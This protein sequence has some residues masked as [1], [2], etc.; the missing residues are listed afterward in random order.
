MFLVAE[1]ELSVARSCVAVGMSRSTYYSDP[2]DQMAADCDVISV[3]Q[4]IIDKH[5]GWGFWKCFVWMRQHG[6]GWNHKRIYRVYCNM[7]LNQV[8][9]T[10]KRIPTRERQSIEVVPL[11]NDTWALDFMSDALYNGRRFRTLN[12]LDEGVREAVHIEVDTSLPCSRVIRVL[13]QLK[14]TRGLPRVIRC[15]NGPEFI[16]QDMADWCKMNDIELKHI[17]PGKPNQNP[18]VE[19]FNRSYRKEV[20]DV[21]LFEDL[22]QVRELS[23]Q[24]LTSYNEERPHDALGGLP[25]SVYRQLTQAENSTFKLS[26]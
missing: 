8:R 25:P 3:L 19:R 13:E 6:H 4:G 5:H 9:R 23:N 26:S 12:I 14:A 11:M 18:F 20:L 22:E 16:A 15:D 17:Q 10:K 21:Y 24:W 2:K 7:G 1:Y